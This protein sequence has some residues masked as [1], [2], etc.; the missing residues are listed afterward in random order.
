MVAGG[1]MAAAMALAGDAGEGAAQASPAAERDFGD[2]FTL[3]SRVL[4][5]TRRINVYAPPAYG[6][7]E[8][9]ARPVLYM[10]DGGMAE[11]FLHVAGL[12]QV[13]VLNG[14]MRPFLLVGIENTNR[15][16]DL[17]G[18]TAV[19]SDL[20]VAIEP[21]GSAAFRRFIRTELMPTIAAR[22]ATTGET[23]IMGESLAGLFIV[24][25]FFLEPDLFDTFVAFDP[26]LW[27]NGGAL[28]AE[29]G[30][31]L[32]DTRDD[33]G[34]ASVYDGRTLWLA[35]SSQGEIAQVTLADSLAAVG[36][37][38]AGPG[39]LEWFHHAMPGETHRTIYHSAALRAVR[40]LFGGRLTFEAV[41]LEDSAGTTANAHIGDVDGD[42][43]P[44]IVL[45]RGRH[46]PVEQAVLLNDGRGG[47]EDRRALRGDADRT[48]TAA[49]A[50]LDG[51]GDPDLV[52]GNDRPD[53]KRVYHNDGGRFRLAGTFG[54]AG[55]ATRNVT[56]ADLDGDLRP[57]M[58]VAN[59]GG[60]RNLSENYYC[61]ND[62]AGLFPTCQIL[63]GES[64]T[65]IGAADV[66]GD[67]DMDLVVPHRDGGQ[68]WVFLND[69]A[70]GFSHTVPV[71]PAESATR[72]V[73][74]G[75]LTG[76]GWP[77]LVMGDGKRGGA[78]LY[79]NA[80]GGRFTG[81]TPL[82]GPVTR[83][84]RATPGSAPRGTGSG[85]EAYALAIADLNGDGHNDLVI[86]N[87]EA[88]GAILLYHDGGGYGAVPRFD[89]LPFGDG[90][91]S[92]YGLAVADV[93]GDG[94][95]DIVAAR[96]GAP[97]TL[98]VSSCGSR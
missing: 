90:R 47:F 39:G 89:T 22:Y 77:D 96:S 55:W 54:D 32:R 85:A 73:A 65:T 61:L 97:S 12:L 98:Y 16:R 13:S 5:E 33:G 37:A 82:T 45:A 83:G 92:V 28:V 25:T 48:Y 24:E 9:A 66:D 52:V 14:T 40:R 71:G 8:G 75:D 26:S 67:G 43:D 51:D 11:D 95:R 81:P 6:E 74:M 72:A 2:S 21:G 62:G 3:D 30:A 49:L 7:P 88:P 78:V 87:D 18:P 29:A 56:L 27:W 4:G 34:N 50:D 84:D 46:W 79:V 63:S 15:R 93:T 60:P 69:G 91:G 35:A 53:E 94:C 44:D 20:E 42:V 58:V 31:R 10:P 1:L 57:D 41:A 76:D 38:I 36:P 80:G 19:A 64:A 59:R 17:T 86:G 23:A 70:A 68:S